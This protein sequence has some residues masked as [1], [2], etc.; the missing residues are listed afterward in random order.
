MVD[1]QPHKLS[2]EGSNPFPA[3]FG[4]LNMS[5]GHFDYNQHRITDIAESLESAILQNESTDI[6]KYGEALGYGF[7]K[8]TIEE[9]KQGLNYLKLAVIY[10]QRIDYLLSGDDGEENFHKRLKEDLKEYNL[11][12][13]VQVRRI[14]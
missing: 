10:A 9:F 1:Y 14:S 12:P 7:S 2:S 4:G 3:I 13:V 8:E 11:A 6:N 5:G